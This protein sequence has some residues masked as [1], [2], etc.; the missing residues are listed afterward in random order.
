MRRSAPLLAM[1][2]ALVAAP[3][4]ADPEPSLP[5][6]PNRLVD[7]GDA[8]PDHPGMTYLDVIKLAVPS[9][10]LSPDDHRVEGRFEAPPRNVDGRAADGDPPD[11]LLLGSMEDRRI[12]VGGHKR[13]VLLAD[14]GAAADNAANT[15]LMV[16][17]DDEGPTP[18]V[19]DAADIVMDRYT[20]FTEQ[21]NGVLPI[22]EG[23]SALVIYSEHAD[24]DL[25]LGHYMI[26]SPLGDHLTL[27][28]R[29]DLTSE[30]LCSWSGVEDAHFGTAPDPGHVY[31]RIE[32]QV[33]AVFKRSGEAGCNDEKRPKA[34]TH[35]FHAAWRWNAAAGRFEPAPANFDGLDALNQQ[36]FGG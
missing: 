11:P 29:F 12:L 15:A 30:N 34:A 7:A 20:G 3:V 10:A 21:Q 9:L 32:A 18:K 31:R 26:V 23:A 4:A 2:A 36:A 24:A 19:L 27:I 25:T 17:F 33:K 22:G 6:D 5:M 1:L 8:V 13:L 14:L 35:R 16:L 28:D